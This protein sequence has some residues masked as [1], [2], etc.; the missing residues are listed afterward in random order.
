[1]TRQSD[2]SCLGEP[3]PGSRRRPGATPARPRCG[4][5]RGRGRVGREPC[6]GPWS[7]RTPV[8][9]AGHGRRRRARRPGGIGAQVSVASARTVAGRLTR[10]EGTPLEMPSGGLKFPSPPGSRMPSRRAC[11]CPRRDGERCVRSRGGLAEGWLQLDAGVNREVALGR[12]RQLPGMGP[13]TAGYSLCARSAT[14]TCCSTAT[15]ASSEQPGGSAFPTTRLACGL[16]PR[17]G[18]PGARTR[19]TTSGRRSARSTPMPSIEPGTAQG[20][21]RDRLRVPPCPHRPAPARRQARPERP[22][23]AGGDILPEHRHGRRVEPSWVEDPGIVPRGDAAARRVLRRHAHDVRPAPGSRGHRLPAPRLGRAGPDPSG[24]TVTYGE[25]AGR[26]VIRARPGETARRWLATAWGSS[27]RA[28]GWS[29]PTGPSPATRVASRG[30]RI[31]SRSRARRS[32]RPD[33]R[34]RRGRGTPRGWLPPYLGAAL[35]WGC[36]LLFIEVGLEALSP[37]RVA[38]GRRPL[39]R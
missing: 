37:I 14:R 19:R 9:G 23:P 16:G 32:P 25:L 11:R 21:R 26:A 34:R 28:I 3:R 31:C 18:V 17:R 8:A 4:P 7:A 24:T 27:C 6:S 2:A 13:W 5:V 30:R 10:A 29:A 1:M 35:I 22:S 33:N 12:L 39:A 38:F 36:S 15:L 20:P